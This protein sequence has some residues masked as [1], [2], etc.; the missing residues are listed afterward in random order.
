MSILNSVIKIFVGDK[1]QK[2]L[3]IL[4]PIVAQVNAFEASLA[5]LSN[6]ALRAKTSE[7]KLKIAE[8]TKAFNDKISELETEAENAEID[9]QEDIFTNRFIKRSSI[10]SFRSCFKRNYARSF[11]CCKRNC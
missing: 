6:D 1:Q 2:D 11:C 10:R 3:K 8:A 4:Q 9:R 7:F 5:D